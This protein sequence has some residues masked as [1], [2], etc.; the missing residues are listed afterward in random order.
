DLTAEGLADWLRHQT[1]T[2]LAEMAGR[3]RALAKPDA[4]DQVARICAAVAGVVAGG[5]Q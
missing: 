4:A 1:R 2:S 3:A 5:K